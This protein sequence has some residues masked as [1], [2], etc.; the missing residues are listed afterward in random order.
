M[1]DEGGD[2]RARTRHWRPYVATGLAFV[3][4]I[5]AV[6]FFDSRPLADAARSQL[7]GLS[8]LHY[9]EF[10]RKLPARQASGWYVGVG[11]GELQPE[12]E[13]PDI[14]P[15]AG[16]YSGDVQVTVEKPDAQDAVHC[17]VDGSIPTKRHPRYAGPLTL[18]KTTVVRCRTFRNGHQPSTAITRTF[19]LDAPGALP[20]LA[21]TVDPTN[22]WN[23]YTGIYARFSERGHEW[24]RDA[25]VEY[26]PRSA[27]PALAIPGRVRIHGF[28][29]R[30]RPKKSFRFYYEPLPVEADD[31]ENIFTQST[32]ADERVVV[33]G[34][35]E[36]K[37]S[38][39]E[40]FQSIYAA[41][42]GLASDNMPV[43]MYLN[44]EPW[45]IYY[46]RERIDE[47][48]LQRRVGPGAYDLLDAQPGK[49]RVIAGDRRHWDR[50]IEFFQNADLSDPGAFAAAGELVDIDNFTDFWLFNIYAANRDWPHHNM[51]MFRS[52]D[53]E[54]DR[55]RWIAWDA[56]ATFD[57]MGK[58]LQHDTL[59]WAT[60][61][62]LRHDLR[63]N[64]EA[65]LRDTEDLR[66]S[67][68]IVRK[69]LENDAYREKFARRMT[70]LLETRLTPDNV[71]EA[72]DT[73]HNEIAQDL[74]PDW[75]RWD[76]D[77]DGYDA[78]RVSYDED[79]TRLRN[80]IHR[81]PAVIEELFRDAA[82]SV[83]S[84]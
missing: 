34:A 69:L 42:G 5:L 66:V 55:W 76:L 25:A 30:S 57:F 74:A 28:Y 58:G 19:L 45:G 84:H 12:A 60:R 61:S 71:E 64:N 38:R 75:K 20:V 56:D 46:V 24:E 54:D 83:R 62:T 4:L 81:R 47:E 70:E 35:R 22:L 8:A 7:W 31:S 27:S 48:F 49:P 10:D 59:A 32:A 79:L 72:L 26:F 29:S 40:L 11:P 16:F 80:F 33:F 2:A 36:A 3:A 18:R 15:V 6:V 37:V 23:K 63:L 43:F 17:S 9:A 65:G 50:T 14:H 68:L 51:N 21:M 52:R 82:S 77:G 39:D 1:S 67:T 44:G 41:A 53:G 73:L 78:E 13:A